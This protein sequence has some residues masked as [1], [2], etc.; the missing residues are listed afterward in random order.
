MTDA[1]VV[2]WRDVRSPPPAGLHVWRISL[3]VEADPRAATT[4]SADELARARRLVDPAA[5]ARHLALRH[6][7][8]AILAR[9]V[10]SGPA[11][12]RFGRE[13]R[14][15]PFVAEPP[16]DWTFNLS[17]SRELALLAVSRTGPVGVDLEHLRPLPRRDGIARRIFAAAQVAALEASPV[18]ARDALFFRHW[19]AFEAL[20]KATGAG[21]AGPRADP[22]DWQVRHFVPAPGAIAALAHRAAVDAEML[23]FNY[24]G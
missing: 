16:T 6:A 8:R 12:L 19:T 3:S 7:L 17:D 1:P 13:A 4:L 21:L 11:Q 10:D 20:Q 18:E 15:K 24:A 5:R 14:G 9:Y 22:A 2:Q 23:F